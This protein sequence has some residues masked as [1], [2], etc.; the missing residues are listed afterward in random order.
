M[1]TLIAFAAALLLIG[2]AS[3]ETFSTIGDGTTAT[4]VPNEARPGLDRGGPHRR[5]STLKETR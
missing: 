3:A 2:I 4:P 1:R 5:W